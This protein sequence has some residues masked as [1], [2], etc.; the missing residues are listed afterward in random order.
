MSYFTDKIRVIRQSFELND[1]SDT[2]CEPKCREF[3]G[4]PL[5]TLSP[6]TEEEVIKI[7]RS[8]P[9]KS[10]SLDPLPTWLLKD[11]LDVLAPVIT[12]I[13]NL[14]L[15]NSDI[16]SQLKHAL[17]LPLIKKL[18][19]DPEILKNYRPVSNLPY[20]SKLIERIVAARLV[21][22]L[23]SNNLYE[24][25][26]SA[27]RQLHSTETALLRVQ[28]DIQQIVDT[29][30]AAIL[31]LLDLSAAFDTI[32]HDRL[33]HIL[34]SRNGITGPALK[35]FE[36]YLSSRTQSVII[37][38]VESNPSD[39]I[40]GVPQGSVLGPILFTIYTSPLGDI[41]RKYDI[42]FH[43]Y[44]DDTQLYL[45]FKFRDKVSGD[46]TIQLMQQCVAEIKLWMKKNLLKLNDDKTEFLIITTKHRMNM[47]ADVKI[48]IGDSD[49]NPSLSARNLGVIFD[50][51]LSHE[52]HVNSICKKAYSQIRAIGSIRKYLDKPS[53]EKLVNSLVTVHLD[54]CNSL[55]YGI[56]SQQMCRLQKI[57]NTAA[58]LILRLRKYD[59]I[60]AAL[61][62]LHWLPVRKRIVFKILLTVY[63]V[64]IGQ[65]PSYISDM[66]TTY[67][68][69]RSLRSGTLPS[70]RVPMTRLASFGDRCFAKVAPSLWNSLP[71]SVKTSDSVPIFK[72]RLKT[73]LFDCEL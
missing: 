4:T 23:V 21:K 40:W 41:I 28:N 45:S 62:D 32:D 33:L 52:L 9:T 63:K 16:P 71:D 47:F 6:A 2:Q 15:S 65:A 19:L 72:R 7:I 64:T 54:Y 73:Y 49:I 67:K 29:D 37:N 25:Y 59:H 13:V 8:S 68:P 24:E 70:F 61:R 3:T 38:G 30:G 46:A 66:L 18:L 53:T 42:Q 35:W 58:R 17:I 26:Q 14:S 69:S 11:C 48:Q 56:S 36:S 60:S 12:V 22:H 27:Y 1:N 51:K 44:A 10:C 39:L 43:L 50:S 31:I 34:E 5:D 20:I 57:Q 55:L